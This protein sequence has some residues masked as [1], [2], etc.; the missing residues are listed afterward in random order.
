MKKIH[1]NKIVLGIS[2]LCF[3]CGLR[4]QTALKNKESLTNKGNELVVK[5]LSGSTSPSSQEIVERTWGDMNAYSNYKLALDS[6][7][8]LQAEN[9]DNANLNYKL[10]LCYFFS[11]DEQLKALPYLKKAIKNMDDLYNFDNVDETKAPYSALYF[12]AE[13]YLEN[14]QPDSALKYY[15]SYQDKHVANAINTVR[16]IGWSVNARISERN[17]RNVK[18]KGI[19]SRINTPYAETNPVVTLNNSTL[20]FS[21]RRPGNETVRYYSEDIYISAKETDG[22]WGEPKPFSFNTELDEAPLYVSVDGQTLYFKRFKNGNSDFYKSSFVNGAF[23][24]PEPMK[25]LNS[26]F[27]EDGLAMTADGKTI[28]FSSDRNK[29]AGR[30]DIF[31]V[32]LSSKGNWSEPVLLSTAVNTPFDEI[33]PYV[34]PDGSTLFFSSRSSAAQGLGGFDI[35]YSELKGEKGW[36]EPQNMRYPINKCRND[37]H[38]YVTSNDKRY[39][40]SLTENNSYDIF[41]AEGGGFDFENIAAGTDVVTVTNEMGVTQLMETEKK[42]EKEVEVTQAVETV[43]EKEKE[44]EV[45]KTVEV[46]KEKEVPIVTET[47]PKKEGTLKD[48]GVKDSAELAI[49]KNPN[50]KKS[51]PQKEHL[52]VAAINLDNLDDDSKAVLIDIV[53][54]YLTR[55]L[56]Q[57]ESVVYKIV[58]FDLNRKNL[59][60]ITKTELKLLVDFM[61]EQPKTKIEIVGHTDDTGLWAGN[62]TLSASRANEV[63]RYLLEHNV[64]MSR[65]HFYGKGS[66]SPF[67]SNDTEEG[68]AKNRRV[69]IILIK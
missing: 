50:D 8:P 43:V 10:G 69:E 64:S 59:T 53:K 58:Y 48:Q 6:W 41:E 22:S 25:E 37:L 5:E 65:M 26:E 19:G 63:Y 29:S 35:Y 66:S 42:V 62:N 51:A 4:A 34:T 31:K 12:L 13:T 21:S 11:Y 23:A 60:P 45:I 14:N 67:S 9:P 56:K 57:N 47:D 44:V 39:Y 52:D 33:S 1:L 3:S 54:R 17:P 2:L 61:K 55:E 24:K 32:T 20:Y 49:K 27:N 18:V 28:Y 36:S 16:G 30:F 38:Y 7:Q 15:L 46:E 68:K 40:S